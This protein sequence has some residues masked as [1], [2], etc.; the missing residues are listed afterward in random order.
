MVPVGPS[1]CVCGVRVLARAR[2]RACVC[3]CVCVCVCHN[4]KKVPDEWQARQV[5]PAILQVSSSK[6]SA[7]KITRRVRGP[8]CVCVVCVCVCVCVLV[9]M[10]VYVLEKDERQG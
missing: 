4:G 2:E 3:V 1:V 5:I 8:F 6:H 10:C 9:C 7:K